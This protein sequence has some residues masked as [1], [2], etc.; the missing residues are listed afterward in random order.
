[1]T[2]NLVKKAQVRGRVRKVATGDISGNPRDHA[3]YLKALT[4]P[5][6]SAMPTTAKTDWT[7][8]KTGCGIMLGGIGALLFPAT[9]SLFQNLIGVEGLL[10]VFFA[11][12]V[13]PVPVRLIVVAKRIGAQRKRPEYANA[14]M[15]VQL[16]RRLDETVIKAA[17]SF[18]SD[19]GYFTYSA[20]SFYLDWLKA[21][22]PKRHFDPALVSEIDTRLS[23]F[24]SLVSRY[25]QQFEVTDFSKDTR[26]AFI[27][28]KMEPPI[29]YHSI[30]W[31]DLRENLRDHIDSYL[32]PERALE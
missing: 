22:L 25:Q 17:Q 8:L 6:A 23:F 14:M 26:D 28:A 31:D 10:I 3:V 7:P 20:M 27:E 24:E 5:F 19:Y 11:L 18:D 9:N 30:H 16:L 29:I 13:F 21:D 12:L 4:R 2:E 32:W 15:A 1:M